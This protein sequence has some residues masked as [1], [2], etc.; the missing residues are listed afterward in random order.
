MHHSRITGTVFVTALALVLAVLGAPSASAHEFVASKAGTITGKHLN[1]Q[2][3]KTNAGVFECKKQTTEGSVAAGSQKA[4][5]V[6]VQFRECAYFG[7]G[8]EASVAEFELSAEGTV[9]IKKLVTLTVPLAECEITFPTAGNSNLKAATYK[10][11]TGGK[12]EIKALLEKMS[13][14]A[15]GGVCGE[16]GAN[17]AF[18]GNSEVELPS[19][20]LEWK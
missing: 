15:T 20:T 6:K 18:S 1:A 16:P 17:G 4:L 19:G 3:F 8:M 14:G 9:T 5:I 7:F 11:L 10:N 13:Y 12:L 2:K